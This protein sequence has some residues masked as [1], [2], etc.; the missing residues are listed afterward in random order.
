MKRLVLALF[1]ALAVS[2]SLP[3][4]QASLLDS[5]FT[6]QPSLLAPSSASVRETALVPALNLSFS[7]TPAPAPVPS[8]ALSD[9]P[10]APE[11]P[12][13]GYGGDFGYRWHLNA[14][15]EYV[16]F[17]STPFSANMSGLHTTLAYSWNDWFAFEGDVISAF[18]GDVFAPGQAASYVL[19]SGGGHI[20]WNR[21]PHRWSPWIH[22]LVGLAHVNPQTAYSSKKGFAMQAG[23]GVDYLLNPRLSFRGQFDYVLTRLYAEVQ[24]NYQ[25]GVGFVLHF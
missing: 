16:H 24:N 15:Y 7:E 11:P 19:L 2:A 20:S 8:A 25:A 22:V 1:L 3:A 12:Q 18:G 4:Q 23:G 21:E 6:M 5:G 17:S 13:A 9:A 10:A 14:G